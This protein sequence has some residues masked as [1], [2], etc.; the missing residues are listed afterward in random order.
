MEMSVAKFLVGW[1]VRLQ[2]HLSKMILKQARELGGVVSP[3][4]LPS[5]LFQPVPIGRPP[6]L[7]HRWQVVILLVVAD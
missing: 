4:D 7:V 3:A 6:V 5:D 2:P 1:W